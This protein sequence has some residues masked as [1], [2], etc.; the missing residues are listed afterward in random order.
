M[1][2]ATPERPGDHPFVSAGIPAFPPFMDGGAT[3]AAASESPAAAMD[4]GARL[5]NDQ[6]LEVTH[7]ANDAEIAQ[8]EL[9]HA[10]SRDGR[11][12]K[13]AA[14]MLRDHTEAE[15]K[16]EALA[17]KESLSREPSPQSIELEADAARATHSLRQQSGSQFDRSYLDVQVREHR[18]VLDLLGSTLIPSSTDPDVTAYLHDVKATVAEHLERAR[19]LLQEIGK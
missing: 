2:P 1:Y 16:G 10:K 17:R 19:S 4:A 12:Q 18:A 7:T 14:Q 11:V 6:I 3:P 8:A 13:L 5:T 9:A 15:N